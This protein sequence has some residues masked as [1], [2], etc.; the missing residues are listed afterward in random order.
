MDPQSDSAER[1]VQKR[2]EAEAWA[3]VRAEALEQVLSQVQERVEVVRAQ[4]VG[5]GPQVLAQDRSGVLALALARLGVRVCVQALVQAQVEVRERVQALVQA[6]VQALMQAQVQAQAQ[7]RARA[8]ARAQVQTQAQAEALAQVW[9]RVWAEV[10]AQARVHVGAPAQ[11]QREVQARVQVQIQ[12]EAHSVTYGEVLADSGLMGIFNSLEPDYRQRLA[13]DLWPRRHKYW[14]F[15]QI[16]APITRLPPELLQEILF[17]I[18]DQA[19]HSPLPLIR[20]SKLWRTIVT[21]IWASLKLGTTT[22]KDAVTRKL[23]RNQWLLDVLVDTEIDRGHFTP[24]EDTYRAIFAAIEATPRWRTFVV[25]TFPA[26]TDLPD[27]LVN[28]ALQQCSDLVLN[29][30]R[31]FKIKRPCEM[32]PLL[33]YLLRILGN[34]ASEELT[35]VEINSPSVISFLA[36]T[37]PSIF[38]SVTVLCLDTPG[39]PNPVD[40]LPH[41]HRL[42]ELTASHLTFPIY[43]NDVNI[44]FVHT[45][46]HLTYAQSCLDSVDEWQVLSR[47]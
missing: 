40:L 44:P 10:W 21:G 20:V 37:Y 45:L 39:L 12:T 8:R 32:S 31:T 28:R 1:T 2:T 6:R 5:W 41:L 15:I 36:L 46:R 16:I 38:H 4:T 34:T 13:R 11:V 26:Q 47:S 3:V 17:I 35:T 23:E 7:A 24:S 43:H 19:S 33:E 27:R 9:A 29:R 30:L 25:E 22:P 14:W 18:I 42:E